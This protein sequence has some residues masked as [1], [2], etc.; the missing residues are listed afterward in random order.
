MMYDVSLVS[1]TPGGCVAVENP[2][3]VYFRSNAT[4]RTSC[5]TNCDDCCQFCW[6]HYRQRGTR[7]AVTMA[8]TTNTLLSCL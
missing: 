6:E 5:Y 7:D 2:N 3:S 4:V 1:M 8:P